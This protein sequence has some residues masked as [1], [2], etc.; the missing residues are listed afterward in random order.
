MSSPDFLDRLRSVDGPGAPAADLVRARARSIQRRR[1]VAV[2][3]GALIVVLVAGIGLFV[4]GPS[5]PERSTA[6][7]QSADS[8]ATVPPGAAAESA[9]AV[10][11]S[12]SKA[13]LTKETPAA[14]DASAGAS[15]SGT[16]SVPQA[17][18]ADRDAPA[19]MNATLTVKERSLGRGVE[20]TLKVCNQ[21]DSTITR[22]FGTSQRYEFEVYQG[23]SK[24][25]RWSHDKTF[26]QTTGSL[27][28][29][30]HEC[31]SW[32]DVWD[33]TDD[34]GTPRGPGKY[35]AVGWLA[36]NSERSKLVSFCLDVCS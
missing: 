12:R 19:P 25:W 2:S 8:V 7:S 5:A 31:K 16:E 36:G 34:A 13:S 21:F 20:L 32:T 17:A 35:S 18:M 11:G 28:W 22:N 14:E 24:V 33:G 3:S 29:K 30:A 15:A 1:Y 4:R 10:G 27:S 23:G 6:L 9:G 26:A